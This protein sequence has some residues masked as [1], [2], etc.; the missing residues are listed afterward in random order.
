[1]KKL[2][3]AVVLAN[4]LVIGGAITG[5]IVALVKIGDGNWV[6]GA[7]WGVAIFGGA[8]L[9]SIILGATGFIKAWKE[10]E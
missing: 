7:I 1:M 10:F 4:L 2:T 3:L 8:V 6:S 5:I 9:L